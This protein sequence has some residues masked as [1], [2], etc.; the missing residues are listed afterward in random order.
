MKWKFAQAA[1]AFVVSGGF[2]Q[3]STVVVETYTGT[4]SGSNGVVGNPAIDNLGLFG[5]VGTNLLGQPYDATYVFNTALGTL[6]STD[7][8]PASVD[9]S[10]GTNKLSGAAAIVSETMA[11]NGHTLSFGGGSFPGL[12]CQLK[13]DKQHGLRR[14]YGE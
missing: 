14:S 3:A 4:I 13:W 1:A 10:S 2:S 9:C 12:L 8:V 5:P 11:L 6:T 7:C